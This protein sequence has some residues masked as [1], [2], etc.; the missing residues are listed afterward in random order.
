MLITRIVGFKLLKLASKTELP[1]WVLHVLKL[2]SPRWTFESIK[3]GNRWNYRAE[4]GVHGVFRWW[5]SKWKGQCMTCVQFGKD[6]KLGEA[7][8][9]C[10]EEVKTKLDGTKSLLSFWDRQLPS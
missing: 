2:L 5:V 1:G 10:K 8:S 4:A 9:N 6:W 7:C 3:V